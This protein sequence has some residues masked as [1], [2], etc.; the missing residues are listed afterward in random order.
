MKN[1]LVFL[2]LLLLS[3]GM[4]SCKQ[5]TAVHAP[6]VS[7]VD[8]N[9]EF[10]RIDQL[11]QSMNNG[12]LDAIDTLY[13]K[14][15]ELWNILIHEIYGIWA[16][17]DSKDT[18]FIHQW[19]SIN[20]DTINRIISH[21]IDSVYRDIT[22][23]KQELIQS[24]K[25]LRYY[26]PNKRIPDIYFVNSYL[27]VAHFLFE[28]NRHREGLGIGLDFYLGSSFPYA[29]LSQANPIFS[30]YISRYF[31]P[32]Y[33]VRGA[34]WSIVEDLAGEPTGHRML[35]IMVHN[36]KKLFVLQK[37]MPGTPDSILINYT[38]QQMQWVKDNV[39]EMWALFLNKKLLYE[40]TSRKIKT[41]ISQAP[42]SR[43]M[44][45][46]S[47]GRTA[48]WVG[49]QIIRRYMRRHPQTTLQELL[50]LQDA[51]RILTES[52]FKP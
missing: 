19:N 52:K 1:A 26:F 20:Q 15:P 44:P 11:I 51:Q 38:P 31:H 5:S 42:T 49:W 3:V 40:S 6:D 34:M 23:Y 27:S 12:H 36:G 39:K 10:Y 43:Y 22:P 18:A 25:Y 7:G 37:L 47:P 48:N 33:L 24:L 41:Y 45:K 21:K 13:K 17:I 35:D 2:F 16:P 50:S 30:K 4:T 28:D 29:L 9:P 8:I 46:A 32:R 14:Q